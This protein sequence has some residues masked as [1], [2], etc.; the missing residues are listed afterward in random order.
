MAPEIPEEAPR[1]VFS[2]ARGS[3]RVL[4]TSWHPDHD[5]VVLSVWQEQTCLTTFRLPAA[6]A[7]D[8]VNVL[9]EGYGHGGRPPPGDGL[10]NTG[11]LSTTSDM[12]TASEPVPDQIRT[13]VEHLARHA[14]DTVA[15]VAVLLR[16][17]V[18]RAPRRR[19]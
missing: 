18:G 12:V 2:D 14:F 1:E 19:S 10:P 16:D 8:L 9:V 5:V 3:S 7:P 11:A 13:E 15:R 4:R 17:R 6:A